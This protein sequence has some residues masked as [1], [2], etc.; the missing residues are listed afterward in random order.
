MGLRVLLTN[1]TISTRSGSELYV[2]DLATGLLALGHAPV[3][4]TPV[5]GPL[6]QEMRAATIPV[7]SDLRQVSAAPDTIHGQHNHE[8]LTA[9]LHFP[10]VPAVR[11]CHGWAD[12]PV[13]Q[14]PRILR[15]V[16]VD[17]TVRDRMVSEWGVPADRV[18][19][20]LNFAD[21][22]RFVPRG[23][24]PE[25]P[26]RALVFNNFAA[27]HLSI[28]QRACAGL[29][30]TV[31][32]AGA[33]VGRAAD[34]PERILPQYDLV[35]AKARCAI[36]AMASGAAVISADQAGMGAAQSPRPTSRIFGD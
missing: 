21:T 9:L 10:R 36:E 26:A 6:A 27:Q 2:W 16:A 17:H 3:V 5:L 1:A 32:A 33:S 35:F 15:Y 24:L 11:V 28:V 31:D 19:V 20:M 13:Q 7:V 18:R 8:L 14:F 25:K 12:E 4:Y 22:A 30:I 34:A 23:R 29:G